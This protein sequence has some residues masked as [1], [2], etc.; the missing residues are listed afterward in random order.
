MEQGARQAMEQNLS[1]GKRFVGVLRF[2]S[3]NACVMQDM[4]CMLVAVATKYI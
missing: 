4:L 2:S 1:T 3:D